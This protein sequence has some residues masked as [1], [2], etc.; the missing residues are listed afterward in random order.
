MLALDV[1]S[2]GYIF[3]RVV[4]TVGKA[5]ESNHRSGVLRHGKRSPV[6]LKVEKSGEVHV[7]GVPHSEGL[8]PASLHRPPLGSK[9][10]TAVLRIVINFYSHSNQAG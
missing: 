3:S 8:N 7:L 1:P 9:L 6:R 10:E 5:A 2:K 4:K